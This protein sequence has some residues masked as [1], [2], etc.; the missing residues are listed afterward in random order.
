MMKIFQRLTIL[1]LL[2]L[3]LQTPAMAGGAW[4]SVIIRDFHQ[5]GTRYVL[6]IELKTTTYL[7]TRFEGC[8]EVEVRGDYSWWHSWIGFPESVDREN[9]LVALNYLKEAY[10]EKRRVGFGSI[11][12]GLEPEDPKNPCVV[13]SRALKIVRNQFGKAVVSYYHH[14]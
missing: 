11:G 2:S 14:V 6:V 10:N 13:R 3:L 8:N 12:R 4:E 5:N 7:G 1:L 9:H